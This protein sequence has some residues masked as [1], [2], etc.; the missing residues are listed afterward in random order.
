MG[1]GVARD[2]LHQRRGHALQEGLGQP[3]RQLQ[4]E[5]VAQPA[6]VLGRQ[7]AGLARHLDLDH[8]PL[9]QELRDP[10]LGRPAR[11]AAR[12]GLVARQ[13]AEPQQQVVQA[14]GALGAVLLVEGLQGQLQRLEGGRVEQLAQL[15][16][17]QQLAQLA[18]I[19]RQRLGAA[20]GQGRIAV[21]DVVGDV[22]E[23]QR[24]GEGRRRSR[25]PP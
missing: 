19:D 13:V 5:R 10:A 1:A 20:L 7:Q 16:L 22:A 8:A 3:R 17:A 21:V 4:A 15:G 14:V 18:L 2:Q 11:L 12:A 23:Q 9:G 6:G 24:R 25:C